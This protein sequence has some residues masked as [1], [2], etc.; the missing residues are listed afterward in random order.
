MC[1]SQ[2]ICEPN[3]ISINVTTKEAGNMCANSQRT[4]QKMSSNLALLTFILTTVLY[5]PCEMNAP[6]SSK[7]SEYMLT[8]GYTD[9]LRFQL[10]S[11]R[12]EKILLTNLTY[13]DGMEFDTKRNCFFIK[14]HDS[15]ER[16]CLD[17]E[18][19]PVELASYGI[20][21]VSTLAYDW[22]TDLLYFADTRGK[23]VAL[24]TTEAAAEEEDYFMRRT[25]VITGPTTYTSGLAV[26]PPLGYL[27]WT[28][29][30]DWKAYSFN[31]SVYRANLDGSN[32]QLLMR[33]P[34]VAKPI[35]VTIDYANDRLYWIDEL[36]SYI[37]SCD[38]N[39]DDFRIDVEFETKPTTSY[40]ISVLN[41]VIYW[42]QS[43]YNFNRNETIIAY[44]S[45]TKTNTTVVLSTERPVDFRVYGAASQSGTNACNDGTH[46]CTHLCVGA[47]GEKF[48]C[49]CPDGMNM[50]DAGQCEC[51]H[52][53]AKECFLRAPMC[54]GD[55]FQCI[56][57]GKCIRS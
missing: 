21:G 28:Q 48:R 57:D 25:I 40:Q 42:L 15:I 16:R 50:T 46:N 27:Y 32:V 51:L 1:S 24:A 30:G 53:G 2:K 35:D 4:N 29:H 39:G 9:I 20:N 45:R 13:M 14:Y 12:L 7:S 17:Q 5:Q 19:P 18:K 23:I 54:V 49:L 44:D 38:L 8:S 56:S 43:P 6:S 10:P 22:L 55:D 3:V 41:D 26:H 36:I 34:Q 37:G 11:G 52:G 31:A 33:R 47:P